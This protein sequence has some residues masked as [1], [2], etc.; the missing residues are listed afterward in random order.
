MA[1]IEAKNIYKKGDTV[2]LVSNP[3]V[4]LE[5]RRYADKIYYCRD[6]KDFSQK[7]YTLY[8]REIISPF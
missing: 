5:V 3:S 1:R 4:K 7:E 6:P 8:E 2:H